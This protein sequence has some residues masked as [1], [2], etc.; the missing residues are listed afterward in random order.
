MPVLSYGCAVEVS[1]GVHVP[2]EKCSTDDL[3][4]ARLLEARKEGVLVEVANLIAEASQ[5]DLSIPDSLREQ[6]A[7][8]T[9]DLDELETIRAA[10]LDCLVVQP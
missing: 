9:D 1:P 7:L 3:A 5:H 10:L 6:A 4:C 8:W 2:L